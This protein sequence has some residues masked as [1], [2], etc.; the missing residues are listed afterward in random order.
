MS[1]PLT[2]LSSLED[3]LDIAPSSPNSPT[4]PVLSQ[5]DVDVLAVAQVGC[6]TDNVSVMSDL[7]P[8][9][10]IFTQLLCKL[11]TQPAAMPNGSGKNIVD[12]SVQPEP[13]QSIVHRHGIIDR[14]K[15]SLPVKVSTAILVN[16]CVMFVI[17]MTV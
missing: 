8:I 11:R 13:Q 3:I 5:A 9:F 17:F 6:R 12:K 10:K 16:F 15:R 4:L 1:S 7:Y 14:P 2:S